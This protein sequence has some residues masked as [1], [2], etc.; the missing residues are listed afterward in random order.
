MLPKEGPLPPHMVAAAREFR[1]HQTDAPCGLVRRAD[2]IFQNKRD[3]EA[4]LITP[5]QAEARGGSGLAG[6]ASIVVLPVLFN[7][8]GTAPWNPASLEIQLFVFSQTG[9]LN[10]YYREVS[11][12][13]FG[14]DGGVW[15]W[16]RASGDAADYEGSKNGYDGGAG[17]L[18]LETLQLNDGIVD[19]GQ[20]DNDGPDGIPNSGDDD[21]F[22]DQ[23]FI[24]HP[25]M[26][27]ECGGTAGNNLWSH[28]YFV[29]AWFG[30]PFTTNDNRAGGGKIKVNRYVMAP[31]TSCNGGMIEIGV[32]AHEFGHCLG[33]PDLY[34]TDEDVT[35]DSEGIGWWGLMASGNWNSPSSP[36]H[37]SAFTRH[38][39]GWLTY[40]VVDND[41]PNLCL[42]PVEE[43]PVAAQVWSFGMPTDEYFLVENRQWMGFD[44]NLPAEGI[45]IYH[46]DEGGY[47]AKRHDNA[48][49][50]DETHK[51]SDV[52]CADAFTWQ[53]VAYAD[54]LDAKNNRG[55]AGDVWCQGATQRTFNAVSTPSTLSYSGVPT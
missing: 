30:S 4:G 3:L 28:Q 33:I 42:P 35:G 15:E 36:A 1:A 43:R 37:M 29:D 44:A 2:Q 24:V 19:F 52:E 23:C 38:R 32:F 6:T 39:L 31:G 14:V 18:V 10:D 5:E 7:D 41:L 16:V 34:D 17:D 46:V 51:A 12:G 22:V 40:F 8:S 54:D 9:T 55:D 21:G 25:K 45:V 50:D 53:H 11:Y 49:N 27:G 47:E 13:S 48:V 26:G 20:Y